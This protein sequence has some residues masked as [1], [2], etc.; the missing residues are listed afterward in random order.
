MMAPPFSGQSCTFDLPREPVN[1]KAAYLQA[2]A[3]SG[4]TLRRKLNRDS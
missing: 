2:L 3:D 4:S 1:K